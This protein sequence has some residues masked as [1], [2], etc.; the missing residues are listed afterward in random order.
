MMKEIRIWVDDIRP[1]PEGYVSVKYVNEAISAIEKAEKQG[2]I[3]EVLAV[4][5]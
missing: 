4:N 2:E 3:I 1:A 5:R